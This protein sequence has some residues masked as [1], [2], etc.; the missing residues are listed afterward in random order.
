ML[1]WTKT[2]SQKNYKLKIKLL[3]LLLALTLISCSKKT[4]LEESLNCKPTFSLSDSKELTDIKKNFSI[5]IPNTW[6]T[7]LYYD[8]FQSAVFCADTTKQLTET[9]ILDVTAK[10]GNLILN[11]SFKTKVKETSENEIIESKFEN[12]SGFPSFWYISEG[13]NKNLEIQTLNIFLKTNIDS[14]TEV[15][16]KVYGSDNVQARFCDALGIIKSIEFN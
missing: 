6:K 11:D 10:N 12:I 15:S 14:Y 9:F 2:N 5:K 4:A 7:E 16:T 13:K 8:E 3:P 1:N